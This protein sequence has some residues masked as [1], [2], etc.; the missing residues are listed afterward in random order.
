MLILRQIS[1]SCESVAQ[2]EISPQTKLIFCGFVCLRDVVY[3][4]KKMAHGWNRMSEHLRTNRK[5][6]ISCSAKGQENILTV[7]V[8]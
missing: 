4:Q 3:S 5:M 1:R 6:L 7:D 2:A 8:G